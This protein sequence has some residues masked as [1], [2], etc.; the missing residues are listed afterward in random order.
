MEVHQVQVN[1]YI[2]FNFFFW[3][4]IGSDTTGVGTARHTQAG[5]PYG[6]DK[7][8]FAFGTTG[9]YSSF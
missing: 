2:K 1:K 6:G 7:A 9:L 3:C 5:S 4:C 8:V